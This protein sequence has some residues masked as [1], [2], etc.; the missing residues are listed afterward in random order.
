MLSFKS[1]GFSAYGNFT[2]VTAGW[3]LSPTLGAADFATGPGGINPSTCHAFC[4][5]ANGIVVNDF[6]AR[7]VPVYGFSNRVMCPASVIDRP[8]VPRTMPHSHRL[9]SSMSLPFVCRLVI[10]ANVPGTSAC[11]RTAL[12]SSRFILPLVNCSIGRIPS[13]VFP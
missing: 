10:R 5:F 8:W 6:V 3:L 12:Q 2:M 13:P 9:M 11:S 7:C 1:I 4:P